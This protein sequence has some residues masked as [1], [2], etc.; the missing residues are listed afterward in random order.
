MSVAMSVLLTRP[1]AVPS[2]TLRRRAYKTCWG[3]FSSFNDSKSSAFSKRT[4]FAPSV[5]PISIIERDFSN[6]LEAS[7]S[8]RNN[9]IVKKAKKIF[10]ERGFTVILYIKLILIL[11]SENLTTLYKL[12]KFYRTIKKREDLQPLVFLLLTRVFFSHH[13]LILKA[14]LQGLEF[15]QA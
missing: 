2:R 11:I 3:E 10:L 4:I 12:V 8:P 6:P 15:L 13:F 7:A 9:N 5:F 14:L 1:S